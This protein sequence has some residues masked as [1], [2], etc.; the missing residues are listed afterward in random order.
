MGNLRDPLVEELRSRIVALEDRAEI[1]E[2]VARYAAAVTRAHCP[3]AADLY[4]AD[5]SFEVRAPDGQSAALRVVGEADLRAFYARLAPG[6]TKTIHDLVLDLDGD[7]A[8]GACVHD[9]VCYTGEIRSY[10]G[11]YQDSY[12]RVDGRWRFKSRVFFF[13]QGGLDKTPGA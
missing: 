3:E 4:T 6:G 9:S 8:S 7:Q 12:E 13:H 10:T 2:L 5:G 11:R 1:R